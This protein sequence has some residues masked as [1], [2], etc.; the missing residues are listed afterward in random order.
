MY[1]STFEVIL[2]SKQKYCF[3]LQV[4]QSELPTAM[5]VQ[6]Y[7]SHMMGEEFL[8]MVSVD[9]TGLDLNGKSFV[10]W[11][12]LQDVE[13]KALADKKKRAIEKAK[14][15]EAAIL[16]GTYVSISVGRQAVLWSKQRIICICAR[17]N[18]VSVCVCMR[19]NVY[20]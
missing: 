14:A 4:L 6:C 20:A 19:I 13:L 18:I 1:A 10:R 5:L 9:L 16:A 3:C 17:V 7:H 8:G 12:R 2:T 15:K 11:Y